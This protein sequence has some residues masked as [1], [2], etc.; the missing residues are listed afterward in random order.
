MKSALFSIL[1]SCCLAVAPALAHNGEDHGVTP[2][3]VGQTLEPRFEARGNQAEI[4]GIFSEGQ[5]WLFATRIASSEPWSKL[6]LEVES[7]GEAVQATETSQGV[8]LAKIDR[9]AQPGRHALTVILQG[10]GQEELLTGELLSPAKASA[11]NRPYGWV[12]AGLAALA[13]LFFLTRR[14]SKK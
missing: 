7:G 13:A 9:I 8:Y 11:S 12:A 14:F 6:K 4:T 1:W 3:M 5:L 10:E 2:A